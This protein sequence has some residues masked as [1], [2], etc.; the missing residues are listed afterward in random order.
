MSINRL[1]IILIVA[2]YAVVNITMQ[3]DFF[4]GRDIFAKYQV[5]SDAV[6]ALRI[7]QE[8][9]YAKTAF[10]LLLLILLT[11]RVSFELGF[12]LAF[13]TY[14]VLMLAFFGPGRS[15]GIYLAGSVALLA[16]YLWERLRNKQRG[17]LSPPLA[18]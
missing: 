15:T 11:C 10:L 16:S 1:L 4:A 5:A 14:A 3:L 6:Q 7:A 13:L 9:Y 2:G 12:G 8:A 17:K 18:R